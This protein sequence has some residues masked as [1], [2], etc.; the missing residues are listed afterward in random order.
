MSH[1]LKP[2][3]LSRDK[4]SKVVLVADVL[5]TNA[6]SFYQLTN[7]DSRISHESDKENKCFVRIY[8]NGVWR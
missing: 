6:K 4:V 1:G 7:E 2:D 3:G 8:E 5:T